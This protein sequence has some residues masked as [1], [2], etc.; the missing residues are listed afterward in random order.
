MNTGNRNSWKF[1]SMAMLLP[2]SSLICSTDARAQA[3]SQAAASQPAEKN[4]PGMSSHDT[5]ATFKAKVN[6]VLVPAVVRDAQGE[7]I[8]NL[9]HEALQLFD[10]SKPQLISK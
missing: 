9:R 3:A 10:K 2:L 6:L 8:G 4:A 1:L 7:A 5:P